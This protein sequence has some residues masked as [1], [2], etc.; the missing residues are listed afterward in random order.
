ME[1]KKKMFYAKI[2]I[3]CLAIITLVL[4]LLFFGCIAAY[5]DLAI[6]TEE[7]LD[8]LRDYDN[9][10]SDLMVELNYCSNGWAVCEQKSEDLLKLCFR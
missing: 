7:L 6:V 4:G 2:L 9:L 10:T 8:V 3:L 5:Q 1:I